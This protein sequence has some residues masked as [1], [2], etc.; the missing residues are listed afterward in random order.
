MMS[1]FKVKILENAPK[2]IHD[3]ID[4]EKISKEFSFTPSCPIEAVF[5]NK[6]NI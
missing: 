1:L 3:K 4:I 2:Q 6:I 5:K